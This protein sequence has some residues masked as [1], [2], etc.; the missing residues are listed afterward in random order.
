MNLLD[1][2]V[3]IETVLDVVQDRGCEERRL[4]HHEA[5]YLAQG[6]WLDFLERYPIQGDGSKLRVVESF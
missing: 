2:H 5:D 3:V 1:A 4:L 6:V